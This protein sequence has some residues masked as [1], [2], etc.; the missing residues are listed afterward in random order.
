MVCS[1]HY[2]GLLKD[3]WSQ[4]LNHT[5]RFPDWTYEEDVFL[6]Y[7]RHNCIQ[8]YSNES[9][10]LQH[11]SLLIHIHLDSISLPLELCIER[12]AWKNIVWNQNK[13]SSLRVVL[14]G[15]D[16]LRI[17]FRE[18]Y[19]QTRRFLSYKD[20]HVGQNKNRAFK[21]NG[22][23]SSIVWYRRLLAGSLLKGSN[24]IDWDFNLMCQV[25]RTLLRFHQ[26]SQQEQ[27]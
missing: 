11:R 7:L 25:D 20:E 6:F 2:I 18:V 5:F 26:D 16:S 21:D 15:K 22:D 24:K 4:N 12:W 13:W 27:F 9:I 19:F 23:T 14:Q 10:K 17:L 8:V 1:F 3:H